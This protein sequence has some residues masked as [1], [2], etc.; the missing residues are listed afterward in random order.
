MKKMMHS[1]SN[2]EKKVLL[3]GAGGHASVVLDILK[4]NHVSVSRIYS[5]NIDP[6]RKI[7][8]GISWS[9]NENEVFGEDKHNV[10]LV[11][12]LGLIP[13]NV[14]RCRTAEKFR[15]SGYKFLSVIA[16]SADISPY[17][18]LGEGVQILNGAIVQAGA[19]ICNDV[20]VNSRA[21][22]EHDCYIG[23]MNHIAP[24]ATVCGGVTTGSNVFI[25]AG[26][27]VLPGSKLRTDEL[28]KA[29]STH[30]N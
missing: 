9:P 6:S 1:R 11:N 5:P 23:A 25:G 30:R 4:K 13:G 8:N 2:Q 16:Q 12:G 17:A 15:S 10:I 7:F 26:S 22:I 18:K 24:G 28:V 20:I 3:L 29:N 21:V 19:T 27:V 14:N